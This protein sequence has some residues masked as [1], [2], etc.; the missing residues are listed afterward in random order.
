MDRIPISFERRRYQRTEKALRVTWK[1]QEIH[2]TGFTK[3]ICIGGLFIVTNFPVH[4]KDSIQLELTLN[5]SN[6]V[7]RCKGQV[8]WVNQGQVESFPA[9]F[10]VEILDMDSSSVESFLACC[11]ERE[12]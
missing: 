8:I 3:D 12:G 11:D 7:V 4:P 9:G 5:G 10:G 6:V 2:C 1:D